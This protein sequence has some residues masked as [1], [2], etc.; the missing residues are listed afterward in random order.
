MF[1]RVAGSNDASDLRGEWDEAVPATAAA[2]AA[3]DGVE[4][5]GSTIRGTYTL[6]ESSSPKSLIVSAL[7]PSF[8][9]ASAA[10]VAVVVSSHSSCQSEASLSPLTPR[11]GTR[12]PH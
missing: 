1:S 3:D 4:T 7:F 12:A 6:V 2:E 10:A 8:S 5:R 9:V 11:A